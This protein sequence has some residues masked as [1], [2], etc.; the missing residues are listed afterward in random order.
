M[1]ASFSPRPIRFDHLASRSAGQRRFVEL[2]MHMPADWTLGRAAAV[3]AEVEQALMRAVPGLHAGPPGPDRLASTETELGAVRA[4]GLQDF[5]AAARAGLEALAARLGAHVTFLGWVD[6]PTR[7]ALMRAA[8]LTPG[9]RI[10]APFIRTPTNIL[11]YWKAHSP[12]APIG[13]KFWND[14][15][16]GGATAYLWA[17]LCRLA[18]R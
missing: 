2:H 10:I 18:R 8:D 17:C 5:L 16:A 3:R 12:L 15:A 7:R 11:T 1:L 4:P 13:L 6:T 14:V 9:G